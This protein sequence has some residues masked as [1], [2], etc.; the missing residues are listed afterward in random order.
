MATPGVHFA[1]TAEEEARL[2]D[3]PDA[4]EEHFIAVLNEIEERWAREWLVETDQAWDA[5]HRCLTDGTLNYGYEP[6]DKCIL[7]S[8][9]IYEGDDYIVNF[10]EVEE[11]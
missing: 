5:I 7:G 8:G 1:L 11:V 3:T 2:V 9:T 6:L 4:S 10:L